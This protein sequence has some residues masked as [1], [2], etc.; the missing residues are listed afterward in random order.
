MNISVIT[1][2]YPRFLGDGIAPFIKSLCEAFVKI[3]I[4]VSVIA[5]FDPLVVVYETNNVKLTRFKYFPIKSFHIM[6]H[7][8]SLKGDALLRTSTYFLIPFYL[9]SGFFYLL[10]DVIK[11]KS[12]IIHVHW[13]LPNGLIGLFVSKLLKKPYLISLHGSDIFVSKKNRLFSNIAK[14]IFMNASKVTA[15]SYQ[16]MSE[17]LSLGAQNVELIAWGA[18]PEIFYRR[19]VNLV[20]RE[21]FFIKENDLVV[22]ALGRLVYKKGFENL[23]RIW[24]NVVD[25][26]PN[27]KLIIGGSGPLYSFFEDLINQYQIQE[28]VFLPGQISW[29]EVPEFLSLGD[30]FV[31]PSV[32]DRFGNIDGLP[33][34]LLEA[35]ST[36]CAV[37]ASDIAGI[38]LVIKNHENG[39]LVKPGDLEELQLCLLSLLKDSKLRENLGFNSQTDVVN[40]YNWISVANKFKTLFLDM[41]NPNGSNL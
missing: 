16:L 3:N 8:N 17:A 15:C 34:V 24:K 13:V 6:G 2:S 18:D 39:L 21:K 1:S 32:L 31:L 35:M 20:Y 29:L 36:G 11:N 27:S 23:I 38:P 10:V 5:P 33:T 19:E 40:E 4:S 26:I 41:K 25:E 14:V 9:F 22:I 30:I 37:I 28:T 12:D 7:A